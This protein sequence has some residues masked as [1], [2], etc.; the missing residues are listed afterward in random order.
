MKSFTH[1]AI[2]LNN[3]VSI[4]IIGLGVYQTA[5]GDET[6]RAVRDAIEM[7]YRHIDTAKAYDNERDVGRA[8]KES[9]VPREE[10]FITTKLWNSDH[11][12]DST[13]RAF[14]DSR[15]QLGM[16]YIDLYLIHWPVEGLRSESWRAMVE[17][18][19]RGDSRAIG[20]S[21][22]TISH[23]EELLASSPV[24]PAVNQVEFSPFLY[25]RDLLGFCRDKG[26][27][28]EA[29][30]PL[31]QGKKLKHTTLVALAKKYGKTPAQVLIRWAIEHELVVIP[32][33]ARRSRIEENADVF[34]FNISPDDLSALDGL[35]EGFRTC[36]DPTNV[37]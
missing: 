30:S 13:K 4:P 23:L 34:D 7:G 12:Y 22:Y 3:G 15:R 6:V 2:E 36:W 18:L 21:N 27:Q 31:T 5:S 19:E 10:I 11:G 37:P 24:I 1:P 32:K 25:Q 28:V 26:I 35:D 14:D 8:V 33:S 16:S 9:G 17:L 29:Y 20:V